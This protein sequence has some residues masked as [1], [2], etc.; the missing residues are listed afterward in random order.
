M[1][2]RNEMELA[3]RLWRLRAMKMSRGRPGIEASIRRSKF[4][5]FMRELAK[6]DP[7]KI[8][9]ALPKSSREKVVELSKAYNKKHLIVFNGVPS[10]EF[11]YTM[12]NEPSLRLIRNRVLAL[13]RVSE[14]DF[15]SKRRWKEA[16]RARQHFDHLARK[17]TS[18]SMP[19]IG[20]YRSCDHT[21][22]L[23]SVNRRWPEIL[24]E[25]HNPEA[26]QKRIEERRNEKRKR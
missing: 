14:P 9:P 26:R 11:D 7:S 8:V 22:V 3:E 6:I 10:P 23:H 12:R 16:V 21:T 1:L 25:R 13:H 2:A 20:R 15:Y 24:A 4:R 5:R 17:W 19:E 18:H